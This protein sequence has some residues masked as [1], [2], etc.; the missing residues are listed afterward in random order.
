MLSEEEKEFILNTYK[1]IRVPKYI[2]DDML[3]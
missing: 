3:S 2:D 1:W